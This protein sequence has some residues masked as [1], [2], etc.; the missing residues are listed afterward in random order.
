MQQ[1]S[2]L[3]D[4]IKLNRLIEQKFNGD[5]EAIEK[6]TTAAAE[7]AKS[8]SAEFDSLMEGGVV[9]QL[10]AFRKAVGED[11]WTTIANNPNLNDLLK[12]WLREQGM[13]VAMIL[14]DEFKSVLPDDHGMTDQEI[15]N[16][17]GAMRG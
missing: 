15:F 1:I 14:V 13:K 2:D 10:S 7:R 16:G 3:G 6:A 9:A 4:A 12:T 5:A 8:R 11:M 17:I